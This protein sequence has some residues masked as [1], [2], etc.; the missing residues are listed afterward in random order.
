[1][2]HEFFKDIKQW[3][4]THLG[5]SGKT[6]TF[7]YDTTSLTA[8]Y[9]ASTH[10]VQK[11]MPSGR[12]HPIELRPGRCLAAFTAFEYRSSD[13]EPYN[14]F[15]IAFPAT[16]NRPQ[17]PLLTAAWQMARRSLSAYVWQLPVTT[18]IARVGGLALYGYPKFLADIQFEKAE[19]RITCQLVENGEPIL[20]L[21]GKV[22]PTHQEKISRIRTYSFLNGIPLVANL[23]TNPLTMARSNDRR[24]A[25][26]EIGQ[27]HPICKA[28]KS[29]ALSERP[30][31]YQYSPVNQAILFAARNLLDN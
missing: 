24:A 20:A 6:P 4:F 3:D 17:L 18:E 15:S 29:L 19:R 23:V 26:L 10:Q 9:T 28:L 13:I 21:T 22:L 7:Y 30:L 16:F 12:L 27:R 2:G 1:M 14:E 8:I 31:H 25:L 11:R 5:R